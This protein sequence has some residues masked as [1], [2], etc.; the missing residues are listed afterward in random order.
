M[1]PVDDD[2]PKTGCASWSNGSA[3]CAIPANS[4]HPQGGSL[5]MEVYC[6]TPKGRVIAL[7]RGAR[8]STSPT[9]SIPTSATPLRR[10]GQRADH[11][12]QARP[13]QRRC[14][15]DHDP[16]RPPALKDWL[17]VVKT[18][19]AQQDPARHQYHRARQSHRN[20]PEISWNGGPPA[21]RQAWTHI[22]D[23]ARAGIGLRLFQ[24]GGSARRPGLREVFSAPGA[25]EARAGAGAG[26]NSGTLPAVS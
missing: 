19:R 5:P 20:R 25:A 15:R 8:P 1:T 14:G 3:I 24:D 21:R 10:Q 2:P 12:A 17:A 16:D 22:P 7:P 11:A 23:P 9:P 13:A 4:C 26:G 6:L 18:S